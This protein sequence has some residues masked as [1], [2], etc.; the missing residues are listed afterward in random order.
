MLVQAER[1]DG[2]NILAISP[3]A[4]PLVPFRWPMTLTTAIILTIAVGLI[5]EVQLLSVL[6]SAVG[7]GLLFVGVGCFLFLKWP[8][9]LAVTDSHFFLINSAD[10]DSEYTHVTAPRQN[11]TTRSRRLNYCGISRQSKH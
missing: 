9:T 2:K 8:C 11:G 6:G 7:L 4:K 3:A 1:C 10:D 5:L